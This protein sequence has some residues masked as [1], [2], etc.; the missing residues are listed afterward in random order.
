MDDTH[1]CIFL[2]QMSS[3]YFVHPLGHPLGPRSEAARPISKLG[4][5]G[6]VWDTCGRMK[7]HMSR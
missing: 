4:D 7:G 1:L 2:L 5:V 6:D 3:R